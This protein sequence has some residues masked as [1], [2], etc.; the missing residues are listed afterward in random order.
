MQPLGGDRALIP[1]SETFT[2]L[3][4]NQI[5]FPFYGKR[6]NNILESSNQSYLSTCL[7]DNE[8]D[9]FCPVFKLGKIVELSGQKYEDIAV[10]GSVISIEIDWDCDLG[11]RRFGTSLVAP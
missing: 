6:R 9:P 7:Y 10:N 5:E 2:V 8:T 11:K 1:M 3:I 4:K